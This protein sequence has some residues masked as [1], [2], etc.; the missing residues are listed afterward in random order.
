M[1]ISIKNNFLYISLLTCGLVR[2]A[3]EHLL[4][5]HP[6]FFR[7]TKE[8]GYIQRT[9]TKEFISIRPSTWNSSNMYTPQAHPSGRLKDER[10]K[11]EKGYRKSGNTNDHCQIR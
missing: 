5:Y 8:H 4:V 6:R 3:Q 9:E 1:K 7:V 11:K 10:K 2:T